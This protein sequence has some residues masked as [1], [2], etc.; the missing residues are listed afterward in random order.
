MGVETQNRTYVRKDAASFRTTTGELGALSNMAAGF[1]VRVGTIKIDTIEALYQACR[2]PH[3]ADIQT[4]IIDQPS[5]MTAKMKSK[6]FHQFTREDWDRSRVSIMR[7]CLRVKLMQNWDSFSRVLLSTKERPIVEESTKDA[8]WGAKPTEDGLLIGRNVL[9]RL[10]MELRE[11]VEAG[12]RL[13]VVEP[14][15]KVQ[16]FCFLGEPIGT[17]RAPSH[18]P[19]EAAVQPPLL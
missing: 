8:F 13:E 1:P 18:A 15:A 16:E 14:P 6:H 12:E 4:I 11:I 5:P 9:G 2:Y 3:R 17:M 7:W 10:L 19:I